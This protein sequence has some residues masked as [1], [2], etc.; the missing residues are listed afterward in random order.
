[1]DREDFQQFLPP[2]K[3]PEILGNRA[4]N[5]LL[6]MDFRWLLAR[7]RVCESPIRLTGGQFGFGRQQRRGV[8]AVEAVQ[9][10]AAA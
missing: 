7:I 9:G 3:K 5:A 8:G 4:E 1:M 10:F 6:E 2:L